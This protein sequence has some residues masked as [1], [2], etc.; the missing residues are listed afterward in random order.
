MFAREKLNQLKERFGTAIQRADQPSDDRLFVFVEPSAVKAICKYIFRDLDARY[1]VSIGSDDRPFSGKFMVA[2]N[3]AFD[4]EHLLCSV[5]TYLPADNPRSEER[6][7]GKE[8]RSR[9]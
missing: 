9:W 1:V 4:R 5:L 2:H 3:F 7:V 6:R 8:C